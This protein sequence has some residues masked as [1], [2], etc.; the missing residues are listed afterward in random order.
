MFLHTIIEFV[1]INHHC[2]YS[3]YTLFLSILEWMSP[4]DTSLHPGYDS[5]R[6]ACCLYW[7]IR[8]HCW[9]C[10]WRLHLDGGKF[11]FHFVCFWN[12]KYNCV[13]LVNCSFVSGFLGFQFQKKTHLFSVFFPVLKSS[14]SYWRNVV[15]LFKFCSTQYTC[16]SYFY[17]GSRE[18]LV[19]R[20]SDERT[21]SFGHGETVLARD[22]EVKSKCWWCLQYV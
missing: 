17:S 5:L 9:F 4:D 13:W 22:K 7:R 16:C 20:V 8:H 1:P 3:S 6:V 2:P 10:T 18:S 11:Y 12:Y 19:I 14:S 15:V 21:S